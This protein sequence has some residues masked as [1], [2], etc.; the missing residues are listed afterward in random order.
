MTPLHPRASLSA[1]VLFAAAKTAREVPET[2][3][4][5]QGLLQE[6]GD[7]IAAGLRDPAGGTGAATLP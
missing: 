7:A 6:P 5:Q 2:I 4:A 1:R 3:L